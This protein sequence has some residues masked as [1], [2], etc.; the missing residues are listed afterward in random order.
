MH[1]LLKKLPSFAHAAQIQSVDVSYDESNGKKVVTWNRPAGEVASYSIRISY[2]DTNFKQQFLRSENP[3]I[4]L[5]LADLPSQRPLWIEVLIFKIL[6]KWMDQVSQVCVLTMYR[7]EPV[8]L[9]DQHPGAADLNC[10][11]M[12]K[13]VNNNHRYFSVTWNDRYFVIAKNKKIFIFSAWFSWVCVF[14]VVG[15]SYIIIQFV[16]LI[17]LL[18]LIDHL[19]SFLQAIW[20]ATV[21]TDTKWNNNWLL[22]ATKQR[23]YRQFSVTLLTI[24]MNI[25]IIYTLYMQLDTCQPQQPN[26]RDSE[27]WLKQ[28]SLLHPFN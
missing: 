14:H 17:F 18:L 25:V 8:T 9:E 13:K 12:R 28:H 19:K 7:S 20:G 2:Y 22:K 10:V 16:Q 26:F 4:Q 27:L 11:R 1:I 5:L 21:N 15:A 6:H 3:W 23:E 24:N